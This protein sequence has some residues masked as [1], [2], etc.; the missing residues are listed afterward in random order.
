MLNKSLIFFFFNTNH[1]TLNP[2]LPF[3][4]FP[5]FGVDPTI[6][7]EHGEEL[8][9][10]GEGYLVSTNSIQCN[11]VHPWQGNHVQQHQQILTKYYES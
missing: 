6:L 7:N 2:H 9:G 8:E 11:Y 3:Q 5:F 10:E 1:V 4:T